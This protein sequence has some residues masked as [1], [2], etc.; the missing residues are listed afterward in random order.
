MSVK[1]ECLCEC[2]III[3]ILIC[4]FVRSLFVPL[5]EPSPRFC[6]ARQLKSLYNIID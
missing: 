4:P 3:I 2:V 1:W 5:D 6:H